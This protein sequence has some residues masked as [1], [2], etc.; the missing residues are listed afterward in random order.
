MMKG[1]ERGAVVR[2]AVWFGR[3]GP[4]WPDPPRKEAL[5]VGIRE[6]LTEAHSPFLP[7]S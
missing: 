1:A 5:V 7:V 3:E 4:K 6:T 2:S